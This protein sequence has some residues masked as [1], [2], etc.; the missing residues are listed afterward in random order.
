[1]YEL[2]DQMSDGLPIYRNKS[3][4]SVTL[5]YLDAE[6]VIR[7]E[8]DIA[9]SIS[10]DRPCLPHECTGHKRDSNVAFEFNATLMTHEIPLRVKEI[11]AKE[12]LAYD[13]EVYL[14]ILSFVFNLTFVSLY[15]GLS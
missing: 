3:I 14:L 6:W 15:L 9:I 2:T 11:V 4:L 5:S 8:Q 10:A 7:R 12:Q 1:M 13:S